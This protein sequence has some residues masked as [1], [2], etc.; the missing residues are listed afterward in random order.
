[1]AEVFMTIIPACDPTP[2]LSLVGP[3]SDAPNRVIC[4]LN[5]ESC[6]LLVGGSEKEKSATQFEECAVSGYSMRQTCG[7][8]TNCPSDKPAGP[9]LCT[10]AFGVVREGLRSEEHTSELQ[11]S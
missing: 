1:M 10:H 7:E 2:N 11:S 4:K 6:P 5:A 3:F 8:D 9:F